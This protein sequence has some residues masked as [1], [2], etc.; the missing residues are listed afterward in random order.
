MKSPNL[1]SLKESLKE[2]G[3]VLND[4]NQEIPELLNSIP[5]CPEKEFIKKQ[6]DALTKQGK[7]FKSGDIHNIISEIRTFAKNVNRQKP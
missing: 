3:K 7:D 2:A 1:D 6:M 4:I 5:D